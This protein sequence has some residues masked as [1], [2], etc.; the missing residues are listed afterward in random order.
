MQI[1]VNTSPSPAY[2]SPQLNSVQLPPSPTQNHLNPAAKQQQQLLQASPLSSPQ[3]PQLPESPHLS[4][5]AHKQTLQ[6]AHVE[7][8]QH[9]QHAHPAETEPVLPP[10]VSPAAYGIYAMVGVAAGIAVY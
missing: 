2:M 1:T 10:P 9:F 7:A 4:P 6:E 3:P 5:P 8:Q